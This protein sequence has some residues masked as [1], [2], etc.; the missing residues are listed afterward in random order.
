VTRRITAIMRADEH[1][2]RAVYMI[3]AVVT[4]IVAAFALR[5]E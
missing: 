1:A 4:A 2:H 3:G 5:P